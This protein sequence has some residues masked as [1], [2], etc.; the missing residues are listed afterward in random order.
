MRA[1]LG[2]PPRSLVRE[3][4][5]L[6]PC[7]GGKQLLLLG[8]LSRLHEAVG[9]QASVLSLEANTWEAPESAALPSSLL[10]HSCCSSVG[11]NKLVV[12]GGSCADQAASAGLQLLATDSMRWTAAGGDAPAAAAQQPCARLCHAACAL[13]GDR[14]LI[15]GGQDR[16]GRVLADVWQLDADSLA[17]MQLATRGSGPSPRKGAR[18]LPD[19]LRRRPEGRLACA[20][21]H[22]TRALP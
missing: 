22:P 17:W 10:G 11:R 16:D 1:A 9:H 2:P 6:T 4:N 8:G 7:A 5:T 19:C 15:F 18:G 20:R 3:F 14:L 21:Q 13:A 12:F